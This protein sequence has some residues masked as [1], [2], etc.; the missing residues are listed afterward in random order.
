MV[1]QRRLI[2]KRIKNKRTSN[3]VRHCHIWIKKNYIKKTRRKEFI[4]ILAKQTIKKVIQNLNL[5]RTQATIKAKS[6]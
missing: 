6:N 5:A 4:Y 1:K 3:I 2:Q